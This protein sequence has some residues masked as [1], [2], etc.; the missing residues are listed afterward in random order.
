VGRSLDATDE[1]GGA[2]MDAALDGFASATEMLRAL[3]EGTVSATELLDLHLRRIERYNPR[4]NAI[5]IP[6]YDRARAVAVEAD[7]A[8]ARGER[9]KLLGLPITV[10]D[11]I[12][13]VGLPTTAGLTERKDAYPEADAVIVG[14]LKAAGGVLLGKTNVPPNLADWQAN[15]PI[16]GRTN[17]PWDLDRAPG[18]STGGGAAAL[19]AGLTPLEFGSDIGGSIRYPA[20]WS[21]V[22]GHRPSFTALPRSGHVPG[23]AFPNPALSLNVVGPLARS[24]EDLDLAMDVVAGPEIGEEVAWRLEMPPARHER[25]SDFRVAVLPTPDWLPVDDEIMAAR[26]RLA[27]GLSRAG[28]RV[29]EAQPDLLDDLR[30]HHD[31]YLSLLATTTSS[32]MSETA[33]RERAA[34]LRAARDPYGELRARAIEASAV[35]YIGWLDQRER[36]R[37]AWRA[38]FREWDVVLAPIV[39]V[40]PPLHTTL[41]TEERVVTIGGRTV[42]HRL[43]VAYAGLSILSGL[44]ATAFPFGLTRD[45]LPI[46]LQVIGPYLEDRTPI[47]FTALVAAEFGGFQRPPGYDAI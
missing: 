14:R 13:T 31:L 35:D 28:A 6:D 43:Q 34:R 24:A 45:R 46:G 42:P 5:A 25:L 9:R 16:F 8:R 47:Q 12:D 44:P 29:R 36:Y 15:N 20:A 4:I 39:I 26:G 10:K 21:G 11:A 7:A 27:E 19:A 17:N 40:P 18:G 2:A 22:Y 38:F 33:R 23:S 41:P 3:D 37:A 30:E 32:S 1:S